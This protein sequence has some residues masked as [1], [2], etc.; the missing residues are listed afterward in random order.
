MA[1][2]KFVT[3][4]SDFA[5]PPYKFKDLTSITLLLN[6]SK[7]DKSDDNPL[8]TVCN[9]FLN[10]PLK[11]SLKKDSG[12]CFKPLD[13]V[14]LLTFSSF[15]EGT[16]GKSPTMGYLSYQEVSLIM[17]V[18]DPKH[19]EVS[20]FAP[21]LFLDGPPSGNA[22]YFAML[23]IAIGRELYGLPKVRGEI[24]FDTTSLTGKLR[25]LFPSRADNV[26]TLA[27]FVT[28]EQLKTK[29]AEVDQIHR[30]PI[31]GAPYQPFQ[32]VNKIWGPN[33]LGKLKGVKERPVIER[34]LDPDRQPLDPGE[35]KEAVATASNT[36]FFERLSM[37]TSTY[38]HPLIGLRQLH[39][40]GVFGS[41][42][43]QTVIRSKFRYNA[44]PL[45][46]AKTYVVRFFDKEV[47]KKLGLDAQYQI[48][49]DD[50]FAL[51]HATAVYGVPADT[52]VIGD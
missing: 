26:V 18:Y 7:S 6:P 22:E 31:L 3:G 35:L 42:D 11:R 24:T 21:I 39:T 47:R 17:R 20:M 43:H 46:T 48:K 13:D 30:T 38:S 45:A 12:E 37:T 28:V 29:R 51:Q 23:P 10:T 44:M 4:P 40:P 32:L 9:T 50:I 41:A 27:D 1:A 33:L 14:L 2:S 34:A 8:Q 19:D 52:T 15:P 25:S 16:S 36:G 5:A 49:G